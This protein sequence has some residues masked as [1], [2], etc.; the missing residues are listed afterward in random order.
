M[1]RFFVSKEQIPEIT[2]SDAHQIIHVLRLKPGAELK[3]LDGSGTA[4]QAKIS[5]MSKDKVTCEITGSRAQNP[6]PRTQITIAQC[7]PKGRKMDLIVQKCTE[8]GAARIIPVLSERTVAK[9][10]KLDRWHKIAKEAAEQSGRATV[11]QIDPLTKFE[12]VLTISKDFDLCL[13]PWELEKELTL[14][15]ILGPRTCLTG[16]QAQNLEPNTQNPEPKNPSIMVII[17]PEGG[18]SQAEVD[19]AKKNGFTPISLGQRILR[20]ETA[21]LAILSMISY[22]LE[23]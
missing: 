13:I 18:F 11:P 5:S 8:L 9:G 1:H 16:R 3:L 15:K 12:G 20:T 2:G 10:E 21:G 17:G 7:L 6:E 23:Q 4:Y 14:K 22:E 19:Q